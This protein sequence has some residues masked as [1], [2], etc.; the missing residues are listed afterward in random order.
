MEHQLFCVFD[1][2]AQ[3]YMLV[4]SSP[5]APAFV[6]ENI[7]FLSQTRP[8]RDLELYHIGSINT[9]TLEVSVCD[10]ELISW[11][12]YNVPLSPAESLAP[13]NI[14]QEHFKNVKSEVENG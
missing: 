9:I 12:C 8:I 14:P 10:K 1:T 4:S 5:S 11:D 2:V 6:R 13:L 7:K 3:S